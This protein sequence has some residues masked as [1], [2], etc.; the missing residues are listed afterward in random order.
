MTDA[1]SP[2]PAR[3]S[4]GYVPAVLGVVAYAATVASIRHAKDSDKAPSMAL[5]VDLL[6]MAAHR[7]D[8]F[9]KVD[10]LCAQQGW[11]AASL[12]DLF[13]GSLGDF[14]ERLRPADWAE[15]LLKT[16]LSLG[17]LSDFCQALASGAPEDL[18][19][20]LSQVVGEGSFESL[21]VAQLLPGIEADPQLAGRLGLWGRR[22]V[23]E[24]IGTLLGV[25]A[26]FPSLLEGPADR[27]DLHE[28]LSQ[29]A[30]RRMR[31]IGLRV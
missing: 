15:R 29:G 26:T 16:Y 18:G 22:V 31:G 23:G 9:A 21:A 17:L 19:G 13:R 6:R 3:Q 12:A 7:V 2:A 25:L 30:V 4:T 8:S 24:E 11:Q 5:R 27:E 14:D 1:S 20:P 10:S 28:T